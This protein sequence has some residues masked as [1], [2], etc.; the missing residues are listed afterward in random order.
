M[1]SIWGNDKHQHNNNGKLPAWKRLSSLVR[2]GSNKRSSNGHAYAPSLQKVPSGHHV[3]ETSKSTPHLLGKH[4]DNQADNTVGDVGHV[5]SITTLKAPL[6]EV[7]LE[8]LRSYRL[9]DGWLDNDDP[10]P[11]TPPPKDDMIIGRDSKRNSSTPIADLFS[12]STDQLATA[13]QTISRK[14][15]PSRPEP[16]IP[17]PPVPEP[18]IPEPSIPDATNNEPISIPQQQPQRQLSTASDTRGRRPLTVAVD[19]DASSSVTGQPIR[20]SLRDSSVGFE[21][22]TRSSHKR[23]NSG[24][25]PI[26]ASWGGS[27]GIQTVPGSPLEAAPSDAA[28]KSS[29]KQVNL[30]RSVGNNTSGMRVTGASSGTGSGSGV[31]DAIK[32]HSMPSP[33][34]LQFASAN[35]N[36]TKDSIATRTSSPVTALRPALG[37]AEDARRRT[38]Q[39]PVSPA[40]T[41]S[42]TNSRRSIS[43]SRPPSTALTSS[44]L[45]W[46]RELEGG[47]KNKSTSG[48]DSKALR[49]VGGGVAGKLAMFEQKQQQAKP[50]SSVLG[51]S[52]SNTSRASRMSMSVVGASSNDDDVPT[53]RR[54]SVDSTRSGVAPVMAYYDE[55]FREKMEGVTQLANKRLNGDDDKPES[56]QDGLR[57]VTARLVD[58]DT[59]KKAAKT[60]GEK[61][62]PAEEQPV[63]KPAEEQAS[64][65]PVEEQ[66]AAKPVEEQIAAKPVE[67][68]TAKPTQEEPVAKPVEDQSVPEPA[69]EEA[70]VK[71]AEVQPEPLPVVEPVATSIEELPTAEPVD[72]QA[73]V[74]P[75]ESN[76][77][78][79]EKLVEQEA[80]QAASKPEEEKVV[81]EQ[82][83]AKVEVKSEDK[84]EEKPEKA[85][86]K[87]EELPAEPLAPSSDSLKM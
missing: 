1:A 66:A 84:A 58:L 73:V 50:P 51:R 23:Q 43:G 62:K 32:R 77:E 85:A 64:A 48:S 25:K 15:V 29:V 30:L 2:R 41:N 42:S 52:N 87:V 55:A 22:E 7:N 56:Q 59:A 19:Q 65:K 4:D 27:S 71:P 86:E 12:K 31:D 3:L 21:G 61:K 11:P 53:T 57:K 9:S 37:P 40:L 16:S 33:T 13:L 34:E 39:P 78:Q 17:E 68:Q 81:E 45:A 82:A 70:V 35:L 54:T 60:V 72:E 79:E 49:D 26:R 47:R 83:E 36:R 10:P 76:Q 75:V 20:I 8:P 63:V 74:K 67:D 14:P 80:E 18:S 46:I 28:G 24:R 69:Q 38:W 6:L 5:G 44:R